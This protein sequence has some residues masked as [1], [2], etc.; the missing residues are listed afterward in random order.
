[1]RMP[2]FPIAH[3][4]IDRY[5]EIADDLGEMFGFAGAT[6]WFNLRNWVLGIR[7]ND[8]VMDEVESLYPFPPDPACMGLQ[9]TDQD[10]Q[11]LH[12]MFISGPS[13]SAADVESA[14]NS[15]LEELQAD[16]N[17]FRDIRRH[18]GKRLMDTSPYWNPSK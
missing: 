16:H 4:H 10:I 18:I 17:E 13:V 6:I 9:I 3:R 11:N 1:M 2:Y 5:Q 14:E 12:E 7:H 15:K 8:G